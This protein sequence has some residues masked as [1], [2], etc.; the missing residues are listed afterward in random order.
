MHKSKVLMVVLFGLLALAQLY[1]PASMIIGG[2]RVLHEGEALF[3]EVEPIDPADPFRGRYVILRFREDVA[4]TN[5]DS[6]Q[7]DD[8]VYVSLATDSS[9]FAK[10]RYVSRETPED[11]WPY[12]KAKVGFYHNGRLQ[13]RYPFERFYME[14]SKAPEAEAIYFD[15]ASDSSR[16][17]YAVVRIMNGDAV[18]EN[19]MIDGVPI[20]E[21]VLNHRLQ[22]G[23]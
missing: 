15:A 8:D 22:Q 2:E 13:I 6:W 3:F 7:P 1:V 5:D 21:V 12:V 18:L 10:I 23:E 11:A 17:T 4:S 16:S 9:G 20:R 19:V 14:E